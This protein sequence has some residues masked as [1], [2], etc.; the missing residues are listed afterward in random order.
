MRN[1]RRGEIIRGSTEL[2]TRK[3]LTAF[4]IAG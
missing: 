3:H 4:H 1:A 2:I